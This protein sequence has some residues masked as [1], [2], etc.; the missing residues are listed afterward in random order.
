MAEAGIEAYTIRLELTFER[1]NKMSDNATP[2][3]KDD[4]FETTMPSAALELADA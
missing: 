4:D 1:G 3:D 2:D